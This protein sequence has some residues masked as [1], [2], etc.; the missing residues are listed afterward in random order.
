[1]VVSLFCTPECSANQVEVFLHSFV[2]IFFKADHGNSKLVKPYFH[3][4][5]FSAVAAV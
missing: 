2:A 3:T 5:Y 1:M 4:R